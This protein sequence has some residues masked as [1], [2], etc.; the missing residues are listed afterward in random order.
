MEESD[1]QASVKA[2]DFRRTALGDGLNLGNMT[3]PI[4]PGSPNRHF[5]DDVASYF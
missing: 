5:V 1:V 2:G 4:I 3:L